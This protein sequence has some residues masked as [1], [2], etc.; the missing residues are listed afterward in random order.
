MQPQCLCKRGKRENIVTQEDPGG[1]ERLEDAD[2]EDWSDAA[3]SQRTLAATRARR[4]KEGAS[5]EP[6]ELSWPCQ[7]LYQSNRSDC[8]PLASRTVSTFLLV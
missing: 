4:G 6:P 7:Y 2:L 1:R 3:T 8:G 5:L